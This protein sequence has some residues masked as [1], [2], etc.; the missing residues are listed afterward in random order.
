MNIFRYLLILAF[1]LTAFFSCNNEDDDNG[2]DV[3]DFSGVFNLLVTY[4]ENECNTALEGAVDAEFALVYRSG[5][6]FFMT[7]VGDPEPTLEKIEMRDNTF[8]YSKMTSTPI[9]TDCELERSAILG[10]TILAAD[11]FELTG[12]YQYSAAEE[13]TDTVQQAYSY[14]IM[15]CSERVNIIA[16]LFENPLATVELA[17][18][19]EVFRTVVESDDVSSALAEETEE[20]WEIENLEKGLS[21]RSLD[22]E[23]VGTL[24]NLTPGYSLQMGNS[25]MQ[26]FEKVLSDG[27][28]V[29]K[30][31]GLLAF[32][33]VG[34]SLRGQMREYRRYVS[35]DCPEGIS[36]NTEVL[37]DI[38]GIKR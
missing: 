11:S 1:T 34:D 27:E 5:Y 22:P 19:Y 13:C 4:D 14:E 12:T 30:T 20:V 29:M 10:G 32:T 8:S 38:T 18:N 23:N 31:T 28:C 33:L 25:T 9:S 21:V 36:P 35:G 3:P 16:F 17:G 2:D 6:D 24:Y 37:F 26:T 15:P 7:V